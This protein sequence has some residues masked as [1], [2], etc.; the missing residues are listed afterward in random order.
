MHNKNIYWSLS[1]NIYMNIQ[2]KIK[3]VKKQ[4]IRMHWKILIY[5]AWEIHC[6]L[7]KNSLYRTC[8]IMRSYESSSMFLNCNCIL[9]V[10]YCFKNSCLK[11]NFPIFGDTCTQN[12]FHKLRSTKIA[13]IT[14]LKSLWN[15]IVPWQFNAIILM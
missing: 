3:E 11:Q 7:S 8:T 14:D 9:R 5:L 1:F 15:K 6:T 10:K 12:F 4:L 13:F 2:I